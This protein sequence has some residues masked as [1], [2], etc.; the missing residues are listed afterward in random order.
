[1]EEV[2]LAEELLEKV[3]GLIHQL[4]DDVSGKFILTEELLYQVKEELEELTN[5]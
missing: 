2:I 3:E 1:M 4:E 5:V